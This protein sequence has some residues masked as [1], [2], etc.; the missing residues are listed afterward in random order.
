MQIDFEAGSKFGERDEYLLILNRKKNHI[1][2]GQ[3]S[4]N[5]LMCS[6]SIELEFLD[7]VQTKIKSNGAEV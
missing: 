5:K 6:L 1:K 3:A 7:F 2:A 4:R